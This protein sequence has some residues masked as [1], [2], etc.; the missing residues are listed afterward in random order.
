MII[1]SALLA[2]CKR[3]YAEDLQHGQVVDAQLTVI[4]PFIAA[5]T[6][7]KSSR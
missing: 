3:L 5:G 2:G 4:N 6:R 1:A 7:A